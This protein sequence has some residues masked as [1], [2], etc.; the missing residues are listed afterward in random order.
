V[1][2]IA[3]TS[4]GWR[5]VAPVA[6]PEEADAV[7]AA[8]ADELYCGA[9]LDRWVRAFGEDDLLTR[10]QGRAAHLATE[11]AMREVAGLAAARGRG[12][13]LTLNG[14]YTAGQIDHA[15]ELALIWQEAGGTA[16][17]VAD[18]ALLRELERAAPRLERHVSLLAGVF[19]PASARLFADLGA[20]RIVLP[21]D[22]SLA[23]MEALVAAGPAVE[24]EALALYQRC[25]FIDGMCGFR[26]ALRLPTGTPSEFRYERRGARAVAC[27]LDPEYEGHG[28]ALPLQAASGPVR[29][30]EGDDGTRPRCAACGLA[31]LAA[32]GVRFFKLAGRGVPGEWVTRGVRF[33]R[34]V[35]RSQAGR[36]DAA[37]IPAL[38]AR[39]FG[40]AC[41]GERC[42]YAG[43][44][45]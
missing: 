24:Y 2:A 21:R 9:M 32:S 34:A 5:L 29:H 33:L 8:G 4:G 27:A 31:R 13:A 7:L 45:A 26:H 41:R 20:T 17:I 40:E 14:R 30:L 19:N 43:G 3:A 10:R 23:E 35:E 1:T 38:Y 25:E 44:E 28:C 15:R 42:Y 6:S 18:P 39:T 36:G 16:V 11:G 12:A 37:A 22:L